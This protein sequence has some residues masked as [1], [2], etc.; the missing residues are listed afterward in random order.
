MY[1]RRNCKPN[2]ARYCFTVRIEGD[3]PVKSNMAI[4]PHQM[5]SLNLQGMPI[6]AHM[7]PDDQFDDGK[8]DCAA[9]IDLDLRR[10]ID[11]NDLWQENMN[12][13]AK[14]TKY[15]SHKAKTVPNP[16][17]NNVDPKGGE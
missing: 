2:K 9:D 7:L 11:I 4:T 1:N 15:K 10:G 13:K 12:F 14:W 5:L 3:L 17:P 6:S 8:P 16:N